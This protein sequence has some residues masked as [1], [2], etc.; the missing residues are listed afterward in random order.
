M[1][2]P[3]T[4]PS[5][6]VH[7]CLLPRGTNPGDCRARDRLHLRRDLLWD[8]GGVPSS[9]AERTESSY[10]KAAE[11]LGASSPIPPRGNWGAVLSHPSSMLKTTL[12]RSQIVL[13]EEA[14]TGRPAC[15]SDFGVAPRPVCVL[16]PG[17]HA[18]PELAAP[19][20]L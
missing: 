14:G 6:T 18:P 1:W 2:L 20:V 5:R 19:G 11:A 8:S 15:D 7:I 3:I 4:S 12:L 17:E 16:K 10:P 13:N 9:D